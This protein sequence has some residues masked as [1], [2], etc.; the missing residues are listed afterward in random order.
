M[1]N[2]RKIHHF[3]VVIKRVKLWQLII[4]LAILSLCTAFFLR[5][6]NLR[7]VEL[8]NA[9]LAADEDENSDTQTA[10]VQLQNYVSSH[11]NTSLGG[12][13]YLQQTYQ[14]AYAA[15]IQAAANATDPNAALYEQVE[16]ECREVYTR[17]SSFP[18]Y[19]Q[20]A[21][22][23]L[24]TLLPGENALEN[25]NLP[26]TDLYHYNFYSPVISFDLAGIFVILTG[27][28]AI[29]LLIRVIIYF[30]LKLLLSPHFARK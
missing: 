4:I 29:L 5:Q 3:L 9:V 20:C 10:L 25:L 19:T 17:T 12:G 14:R 16:L 11:M 28:V 26:S 23:K 22:D 1:V 24:S 18:A 21:H 6:N 15:A 27:V 30:T 7:M 8:R 2:K 13:I